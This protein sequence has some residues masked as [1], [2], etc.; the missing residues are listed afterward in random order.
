MK[1]RVMVE[2][3]GEDGAVTQHVISEGERTGAGQAAT[4]GLSLAEGKATLAGLQRGGSPDL[5]G[6][7]CSEIAS[8]PATEARLTT[9]RDTIGQPWATASAPAATGPKTSP[10]LFPCIRKP[11]VAP[12]S[13]GRGATRG[14]ASINATGISPARA[15]RTLLT[16]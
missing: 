8:R 15:E 5:H 7:R 13:S 9:R 12:F 16:A 14:A 11:M 4:L 10:A 6:C 2:V 3:T 1:W